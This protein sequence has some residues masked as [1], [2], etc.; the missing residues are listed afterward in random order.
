[1]GPPQGGGRAG[2]RAR[3]KAGARAGSRAGGR[4]GAWRGL[5]GGQG[6]D[7][8]C[9]RWVRQMRVCACG[10]VGA[11]VHGGHS[12]QHQHPTPQGRG[13][14]GAG[15]GQGGGRLT[16]LLSMDA[17]GCHAGPAP[18]QRPLV[19]QP[20]P[21]L[22]PPPAPHH[23]AHCTLLTHLRP[24]DADG[25][26]AGS[27]PCSGRLPRSHPPRVVGCVALTR[28]G[29]VGGGGTVVCRGCVEGVAFSLPPFVTE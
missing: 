24:M 12:D 8:A 2:A 6:G 26:R 20:S 15:W 1:M 27:V 16:H 5:D 14:A 29:G 19:T 25:C 3:G 22:P 17:D 9:G 11:V 10:K 7:K 28:R 21:A 18:S 23:P 13:V 4:A